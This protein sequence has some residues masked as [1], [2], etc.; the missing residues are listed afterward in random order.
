MANV[1]QLPSVSSTIPS[2][3]Q[4][5]QIPMQ[6]QAPITVNVTLKEAIIEPTSDVFL[7]RVANTLVPHIEQALN[8]GNVA[9]G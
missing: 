2:F 4:M 6:T 5:P 9:M 1:E 8:R 7:K 3:D